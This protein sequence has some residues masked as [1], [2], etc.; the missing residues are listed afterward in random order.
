MGLFPT[1]SLPMKIFIVTGIALLLGAAASLASA[2]VLN[3][4]IAVIGNEPVTLIDLNNEIKLYKT[5]KN[6]KQDKRNIESQVLDLLISR[7]IVDIIA[8]EE[9][10]TVPPERID[11]TIQREMDMRGIANLE[12]Y[13]KKVEK[14]LGIS[15]ED[16]KKEMARQLKTQQV[17]QL[18][19]SVP[20]PTPA[21]IDEWY[22]L[23]KN[24]LGKKY[25]F[26]MVAIPYKSSNEAQVSKIMSQAHAEARKSKDGIASAAAKYSQHVSKSRG[27]LM[28]PYRLDEIAR[29]DPILA[30][31][32]N[33]TPVG[34]LSQVFVGQGYYYLIKVENAKDI[35]VDEVYDQIRALLQGQNEQM[36]FAD[37]VREQRR[38]VS[39]TIFLK[40]YQEL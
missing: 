33:N 19:V 15:F 30:G 20:N 32:V 25:L 35:P 14:E 5:R 31:A 23:N 22:K 7:A 38:R 18:R 8:A 16:Y 24:K 37:W 13:K 6:V 39:V 12:E 36:A 27:G 11:S 28:G 9:S 17:I 40:N 26:R 4:V 1:L 34:Q 2:E 3:E 21:Q 29:M 10:I